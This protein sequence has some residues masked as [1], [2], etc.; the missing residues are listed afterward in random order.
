M[1]KYKFV[2]HRTGEEI[3]VL[4]ISESEWRFKGS[5]NN[6]MKEKVESFFTAQEKSFEVFANGNSL[7]GVSKSKSVNKTDFDEA[8]KLISNRYEEQSDAFSHV[9]ST[10]SL[11][12]E[13]K[14]IS[15]NEI[16]DQTKEFT[17]IEKNKNDLHGLLYDDDFYKAIESHQTLSQFNGIYIGRSFIKTEPVLI[18]TIREETNK[19]VIEGKVVS[20]K[21]LEFRTG[22]KMLKMDVADDTSGIVV[23][24]FFDDSDSAQYIEEELKKGEVVRVRGD[25]RH[26]RYSGDLVLSANGM[27]RVPVTPIEHIDNHPTP[28]VELHLHTKMSNDALIDV[29]KLIKTIK[30]WNHPA[31]AITDHGVVQSFPVVQSYAAEHGVKVI[32]GMEGYLIDEIPKDIEFDQQKYSHIIILAKNMTGLRNLYRLVS[33]SHVCYF[34]KRPLIPRSI[35]EENRE[36]LILGSACVAGELFKAILDCKNEE[37]IEEIARFYDYL[38][39]QPISDNKFLIQDNRYSFIQNEDDLRNLN[40]YIVK[41]GDKLGIPVCATCDSHYLFEEDKIYRDILLS[42]W[43]KDEPEEMPDLHLR[44]TNEMLDEFSYL[45]KDKAEE[46]VITNTRKINE[47]TDELMPLPSDGKLYAPKIAGSDEKLKEMCYKKAYHIYG[48]PLP[49]LV[50]TRLKNELE[51]IIGNG[52][53]VLYYIAHKLV[54]K[55]LDDGYLVGSRGSVGSSFVATMADITE[56]NPLPPHYVCPKCRYNE[57]ITDG[58]VG[59]GFDL[60]DKNCPNCGGSMHKDG[61]NIPFAVFM[62]FKGDKVPDIDLNFSGEY[63]PTAHKYTEELF[64]KDNVFRAGTISGIQERTAFGYVKKYAELHRL[65]CNDI[66]A[67]SLADGITKVKNTTGQHPGG[68]MVCPRDMD[69]LAFTPVQYPANKKDSGII[70]T[71]FDYHSIEGRMVKLDILGHDDPTVIRMLEDLTGVSPHSIPFDDEVTLSLFS[72]TK[73]LGLKPEELNGDVVGTL[74]I[75]EY[76]TQFVRQML[77]DTLPKNFSELVRISGFSHGTDVWLN[78]AKDLITAG[79]VKLEDAISTRDDIM[80]Y[81]IRYGVDSQIAFNVMENVRKGKGL[82]KKNNLGQAIS[83]NEEELTAK[84]IPE[85]FLESCKKISYLFPR[86]HAVAY[87]MMAFRIAWFKIN[88]PLAFYA[89]YFTVRS[90][91][92]FDGQSILPGYETQRRMWNHIMAKGHQATAVEKELATTIE[93]AMEMSLRGFRFKPI[94]L[95]R[96]HA[97]HFLIED[98]MLLPPLASVPGLGETAAEEIVAARSKSGFTSKEDLRKRGKVSQATVDIL[99][100]LG[101]L[102]GIPDEEQIGLFGF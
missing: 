70:T 62:G 84:K 76:G 44:T 6:E 25:V 75:P 39:V 91:G 98:D 66:F 36:G 94:D 88:H 45:G 50:A 34:K 102:D 82:E 40:K 22:R 64:G 63:Q 30:S 26:D 20:F 73:A 8:G 43:A 56:V 12:H 10:D 13:R 83:N 15:T 54:K 33:L 85:W 101:A 93:V 37:K 86:A 18:E 51:A 9:L 96:S 99:V 31:I 17:N 59:G 46:I 68:I 92:A 97:T 57:F 60:P 29:E 65:P 67:S 19:I 69:I 24:H 5:F 80:N 77:A 49:E 21:I 78:N 3:T 100:E 71:H 95:E 7:G 87:V 90:K 35:L 4:Y 14:N 42:K 2:F 58:S 53:G 81:L 16:K 52:F 32:Y 1:K 47:Q 89:S 79:D 27:V 55:S 23:Q 48:N 11:S 28:R 41:L 61:H 38:E 72:S 74:G